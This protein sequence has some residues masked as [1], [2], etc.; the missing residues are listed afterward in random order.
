MTRD[1]DWQAWHYLAELETYIQWD[2]QPSCADRVARLR[3]RDGRTATLHRH[4]RQST[5]RVANGP[6]TMGREWFTVNDDPAEYDHL[7]DAVR[8]AFPRTQ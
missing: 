3:H 7:A 8:V 1:P 6:F 5:Y 4:I 2:T